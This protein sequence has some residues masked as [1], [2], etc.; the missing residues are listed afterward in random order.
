MVVMVGPQVMKKRE[1]FQINRLLLLY[2]FGLVLLSL[3]MFFEVCGM[4]HTNTTNSNCNIIVT[5]KKQWRSH[6]PNIGGWGEF[7]PNA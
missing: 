7:I 6:G 1:A 5:S 3:Y 2:N 4:M